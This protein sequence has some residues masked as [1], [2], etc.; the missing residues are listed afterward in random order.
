MTRPRTTGVRFIGSRRAGKTQALIQAAVEHERAATIKALR[1]IA[2]QADGNGPF[3]LTF[4][5]YYIEFE[6]H[7]KCRKYLSL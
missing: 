5:A 7:I 3:W 4:A 1:E 2:K 6:N